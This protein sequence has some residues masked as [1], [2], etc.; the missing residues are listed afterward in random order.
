MDELPY[1]LKGLQ[2]QRDESLLE[3]GAGGGFMRSRA[4]RTLLVLSV[5]HIL[6]DW[7]KG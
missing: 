2:T 7:L 5:A 4:S 3:E 6:S 1:I